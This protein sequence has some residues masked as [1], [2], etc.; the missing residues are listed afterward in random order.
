MSAGKGS[1][2][3]AG[4]QSVGSA[5]GAARPPVAQTYPWPPIDPTK[6]QIVLAVGRKGSGKS[7]SARTMFRS[8][9]GS[10]RVVLDVTGDAHPGADLAPITLPREAGALPR[11]D[12]DRGPQV[13]RWIPDTRSATYRDDLDRAIGLGLF[14]KDR[15]VLIWIDE[16]GEVFPAN[17][18]G[19]HGRTALHQ[20]RHHNLSMLLCCPRPMGIDP[21][22]I[23]QADRVLMYDVPHP[24]DRERLAQNIGISPRTLSTELTTTKKRGP[25]WYLMYVAAEDQLYRCPPL[26]HKE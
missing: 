21:L 3:Y 12:P 4:A 25:Y 20:S 19:P 22:C 14:P 16:A 18:V 10:D 23:A 6:N 11:L 2:S 5:T 8:W 24:A 1:A 26:P 13:Y 15:P 7:I 17:R 9:P